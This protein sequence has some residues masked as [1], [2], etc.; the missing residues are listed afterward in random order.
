MSLRW[1]IT[2]ALAVAAALVGVGSAAGAYATLAHQLDSSIDSSL[3]TRAASLND[4][5]GGGRGGPGRG[6][7]PD[8]DGT[9]CP[10]SGNL[11]PATAAQLVAG[12]GTVTTC[13]P[14]APA[15]PVADG[16]LQ[17]DSEK[18]RTVE[19]DGLTYRMLTVPWREGGILQIGRDLGENSDV[20]STLR[21]RLAALA[22]GGAIAAGL[23]G[24]AIA[25]R[26]VRPIAALRDTAQTIAAT[27]DLTT[28]VPA[29]A[30]GEVGS[31][32]R[33]FTTMIGAL[34]ESRAA[35]QR[36]I[37]DASHEMRT[38][39]TS[40]TSNLEL[41]AQFERLPEA[42]RPEVLAAI[43]ADVAELTALLTQLVELSSEPGRGDAARETVALAD[44]A[45]EVARRA[46]RR[47]GR[48]IDVLDAAPDR[49]VAV[50][51]HSVE[52]AIANLIDNAVKYSADGSPIDVLVTGG[53]LEVRDH[54]PGIDPADQPHIFERFYRA[55][56]ARSRPGSGLGL[57]I[58]AQT[59]ERHGGRVVVANHADGGAVV[60]FDLHS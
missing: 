48:R 25:S 36:L 42:D 5:E 2:A 37:T 44:L 13:L 45:R 53:R 16:D 30:T 19:I 54:G 57:A 55:D 40:L 26:L 17:V 43:G 4:E 49:L 29:G 56:E 10:Q 38:P 7:G 32:G 34:A 27:Q 46:S 31:L 18:L 51:V 1:R 11:Q 60:G 59:V 50:D 22:I 24:W 41:M 6:G 28:I 15:L 3:V 9:M 14:G 39:L 52:R 21:I 20:L 35:Q 58:V 8:D 23:I 12:D 47:S 33:S